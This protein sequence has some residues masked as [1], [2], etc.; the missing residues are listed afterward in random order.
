M[1]KK[2]TAKKKIGKRPSSASLYRVL[3]LSAS[4]TIWLA[5]ILVLTFV[6]FIPLR[7]ASFV[8]WD[9]DQNIT[10]NSLVMKTLSWETS[11]KIF[12]T[13]VIGNYN[14]LSNW[15][16]ALEKRLFVDGRNYKDKSERLQRFS[17]VVHFDN[18]LLHLLNILLLWMILSALGCTLMTTAIT[19]FLFALH[20][21]H[22]ESVAWATERKDVLYGF[23][24]LGSVLFYVLGKYRKRG[25]YYIVLSLVFFIIGLFAKIQMVTLPLSLLLIDYYKDRWTSLKPILSKWI[26]FIF[27][28]F[29]GLLGIYFLAVQG[30]L[31]TNSSFNLFQR[32]FIGSYSLTVYLMKSLLPYRM[33]ALYPYPAQL[34][35]W[36]YLSILPFLGFL[37]VLIYTY[38]KQKKVLFFGFSWFFVNIVFLLQFFGAGQGYIADRFTYISYIGLFFV[39]AYYTSRWIQ[40]SQRFRTVVASV[41]ILWLAGLTW[42]SYR[43]VKVWDNTIS[44]FTQILYYYPKTMT[45]YRNRGNYYRDHGMSKKALADYSKALSLKEE[46]EMYNSRAKLYFSKNK[47]KSAI[48]DYKNAI[49]LNPKKGEYLI[50]L[51]ATYAKAEQYDKAFESI[52]KGMQLSPNNTNGFLNRSIMYMM[53]G[54]YEKQI[55]D[56]KAYLKVEPD[57]PDIWFEM[58][59]AYMMLRRFDE[60]LDA[61]NHA[62]HLDRKGIYLHER[63][64]VNTSLGHLQAAIKDAREAQSKGI[65]IHPKLQELLNQ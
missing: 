45:P 12:R 55:K 9:D 49:R 60:A 6:V 61:F 56:L 3:G 47:I 19:S 35:I 32:L 64:K 57:S 53:R 23:F 37:V 59:R 10:E 54:E 48:S 30:S 29:F 25:R 44:L 17:S 28:L 34:T 8:Y 52:N 40:R 1:K 33:S 43:Q 21:L 27:A 13:P 41:L 58:G 65:S 20:P 51:G 46:A 18:L 4:N 24:F 26:Y 39:I 5:G 11:K 16:F 7:K 38:K 15:T 50:N 63:A 36:H 62:I 31:E 22:I 2:R 14:P 42:L